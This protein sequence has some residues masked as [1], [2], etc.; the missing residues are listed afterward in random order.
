MNSGPN[1]SSSLAEIL[2][3]IFFVA[4]V[5]GVFV[6]AFATPLAAF[7]STHKER[8][9]EYSGAKRVSIIGWTA[10]TIGVVA[11]LLAISFTPTGD[12]S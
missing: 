3:A 4:L 9:R 1:G 2:L 10:L 7:V 6:F 5:F 12:L 11:L 8:W